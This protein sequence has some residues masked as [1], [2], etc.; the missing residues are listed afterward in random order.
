MVEMAGQRQRFHL[1]LTVWLELIHQAAA[2][3]KFSQGIG[4]LREHQLRGQ[5]H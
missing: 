2:A 4:H 3:L 1:Q 5:H